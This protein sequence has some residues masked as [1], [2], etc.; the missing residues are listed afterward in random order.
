MQFDGNEH[1]NGISPIRVIYMLMLYV[2]GFM[3]DNSLY[4][5]HLVAYLLYHLPLL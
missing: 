4:D 1:C 5:M 2:N 3:L